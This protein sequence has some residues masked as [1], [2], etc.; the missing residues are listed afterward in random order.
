M[1]QCYLFQEAL[2]SASFQTGGASSFSSLLQKELSIRYPFF[3]LPNMLGT[4]DVF[5]TAC[6][7]NRPPPLL[8]T[9]LE[10][11]MDNYFWELNKTEVLE[12]LQRTAEL[13]CRG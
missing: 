6:P 1:A 5:F 2:P 10:R 3:N 13:V 8:V 11:D 9:L 7:V 4:R 12:A